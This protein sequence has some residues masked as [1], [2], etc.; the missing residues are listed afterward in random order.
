MSRHRSRLSLALVATAAAAGVATFLL[1]PRGGLIDAAAVDPTAYFSAAE[2]QRANDFRDPQRLIGLASIGV[3]GVTL[4]VLSLR[5]PAAVRR[6]MTR[7]DRRPWLGAAG[8]GAGLA[9][10][11]TAVGLPLSAVAH[12]RA[13]DVG[14]STRSWPGWVGDV[15]LSTAI[16][17][18]LAA[19]GGV[20]A[21]ALVRRFRRRWWL[22]AAGVIVALGVAS[23]FLVPILVE[24]LFNKFEPLPGGPLRTEVVRL[25]DRAGIDVGEVFRVDASK[26]TTGANAYVGGLG[27]TKRV[28][29]YDNLIE[30]F[31]PDQVR[32]VVAHEMGHVKHGDLRRGLLW[33]AIVAL[34]AA[35]LVQRLTERM[36]GPPERDSGPSV[37]PALA[38]S[39]ALVS[40]AVGCAGNVLSRRVEASADAFALRITGEPAA[41]IALERRLATSNVAQPKPPALTQLLFGTHPTTV[42]RIGVGEAFARSR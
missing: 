33:L 14:L 30:D 12:Q 42:E 35:L 39:L 41:F 27:S 7:A 19:G 21:L 22:P 5:P 6:L 9:L 31:S 16:E 36:A 23:V 32:S 34:P 3:S 18:P 1:R 25:A 20:L 4:A 37:L 28:V 29:L 8:V 40:F 11:L 38:L 15:G 10:V 26:R 13:V 17:L 2:L 24:P